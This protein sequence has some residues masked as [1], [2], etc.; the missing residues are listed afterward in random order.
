MLGVSPSASEAVALQLV[1]LEVVIPLLGKRL[2]ES[3][4]G[5]V[6]ST[7]TVAL[8]VSLPPSG[9]VTETV[10]VITSPGELE[11]VVKVRVEA[12][13]RLTEVLSLVHA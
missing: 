8:P 5:S 4:V 6:F 1:E 2:M 3:T 12:A 7:V 10:Q 9:S 11:D 13:P